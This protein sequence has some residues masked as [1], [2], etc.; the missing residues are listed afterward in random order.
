M[1]NTLLGIERIASVV[2]VT[3]PKT[4]YDVSWVQ[5]RVVHETCE[6]HRKTKIRFSVISNID[7]E[8]GSGRFVNYKT[9]DISAVWFFIWSAPGKKKVKEP[10]TTQTTVTEAREKKLTV[11]FCNANGRI[12]FKTT[13]DY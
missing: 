9:Y 6:S 11:M 1:L 2:Q 8:S 5:R 10:E 4:P 7:T 3:L 13:F 12:R